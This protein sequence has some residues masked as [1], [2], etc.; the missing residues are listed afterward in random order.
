V[1][2]YWLEDQKH[3]VCLKYSSFL[4]SVSFPIDSGY[5]HSSPDKKKGEIQHN[6]SISHHRH[7]CFTSF[8]HPLEKTHQF[9]NDASTLLIRFHIESTTM[10]SKHK[11]YPPLQKLD[12]PSMVEPHKNLKWQITFALFTFDR[13]RLSGVWSLKKKEISV[14]TCHILYEEVNYC[15]FFI[16]MVDG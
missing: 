12:F 16:G 5:F 15:F 8:T 3:L 6:N 10:T 7:N 1:L 2:H 4:T 14:Q 9:N 13:K 11:V